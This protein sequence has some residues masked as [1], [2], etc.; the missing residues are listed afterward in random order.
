MQVDNGLITLFELASN[1]P[2]PFS[3]RTWATRLLLNYKQLSYKTI[4]VH[5]PDIRTVLPAA[6]APPTS[7]TPLKYT[8]PAIIDDDKVISDSRLIAEYLENTY[9]QRPIPLLGAAEQEAMQA[10]VTPLRP[11]VIPSIVNILDERDTVY[12]VETRRA[13]FGKEL[14]EIAPPS[15]RPEMMQALEAALTKLSDFVTPNQSGWVFGSNGPA[16]E[17]FELIGWFMWLKVAG[18]SEVWERVLTLNDG[19][20]GELLV[21]AEP[22]M[23]VE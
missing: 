13:M 1:L 12:F 21:A 23:R 6:G 20:W 5:F 4:P 8:V 14:H 18:P 2:T 3:P 7:T 15:Q 10:V 17:D 22:Y 11:L 9:T 16:Y 19:R